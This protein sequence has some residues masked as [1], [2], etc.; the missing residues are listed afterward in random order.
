MSQPT[1]PASQGHA[2]KQPAP[3]PDAMEVS[4]TIN[5]S[6]KTLRVAPWTS[7]LDAL[8]LHLDM[9]GTKKG[10]DHGQCGACTVLVDGRRINSCLTLAV[11][12][13]GRTVTTIEGLASGDALHPLQE[14]FVEQDAFQCGYCT[15]GQIC[16]AVG[17]LEEGHAKTDDDIRE[18]MS[19][20][21]CR[22]GAYPNIVAAIRQVMDARPAT[23]DGG[24]P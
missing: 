8:R 18:L 24:T 23:K 20:N 9:T 13:E 3:P 15:P 2:H 11:M 6:R 1:G 19:G 17:L 7:L 12:A 14:A 16:S 10:C 21:L 4:L 22:C 5:G